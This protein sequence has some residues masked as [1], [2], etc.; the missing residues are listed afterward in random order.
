MGHHVWLCLQW[1]TYSSPRSS[2]C[3]S[4][5]SARW[6]RAVW[7]HTSTQNVKWVE[8]GKLH[9]SDWLRRGSQPL[10]LLKE[11][12]IHGSQLRC[13]RSSAQ[14][15]VQVKRDPWCEIEKDLQRT[16]FNIKDRECSQSLKHLVWV[17]PTCY[18]L[19]NRNNSLKKLTLND[20]KQTLRTKSTSNQN[21]FATMASYPQTMCRHKDAQKCR[22]WEV[23]STNCNLVPVN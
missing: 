11:N 16:V 21:Y 1:N 17:S 14:A 22:F 23:R 13:R 20:G 6:H 5:R 2:S 18:S 15:R 7:S 10:E 3:N 9:T 12:A 8:S 19:S 4:L